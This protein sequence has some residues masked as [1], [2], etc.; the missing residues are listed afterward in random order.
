MY[1]NYQESLNRINI[2]DNRKI[3]FQ[4]I[5][6]TLKEKKK[7]YSDESDTLNDVKDGFKHF[8]LLSNQ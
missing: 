6:H 3:K 1:I 5:Q 4:K 8:Y 7:N 2:Y